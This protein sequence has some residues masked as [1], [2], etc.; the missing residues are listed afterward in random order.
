MSDNLVRIKSDGKIVIENEARVRMESDGQIGIY[1]DV[2]V[3]IESCGS[4]RIF[5]DN[6][7]LL[8]RKRHRKYYGEL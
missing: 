2:R 7:P 4:V 1:N 3:E 8:H 6:S 5:S